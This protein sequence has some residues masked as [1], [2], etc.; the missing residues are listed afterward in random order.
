MFESE[1][2][3]SRGVAKSR[4]MSSTSGESRQRQGASRHGYCIRSFF[5][6]G[7][8]VSL[9]LLTLDNRWSGVPCPKD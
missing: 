2:R 6:C 9:A 7:T 4:D 8:R 5:G 3:Y 1:E